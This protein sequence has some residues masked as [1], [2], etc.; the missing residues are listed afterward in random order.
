MA[1]DEGEL[2]RAKQLRDPGS[3]SSTPSR[4]NTVR[5]QGTRGSDLPMPTAAVLCVVR[6][7]RR[8]WRRS[9]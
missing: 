3:G 6:A 7:V 4:G 2:E 1:R 8:P 5:V 9:R